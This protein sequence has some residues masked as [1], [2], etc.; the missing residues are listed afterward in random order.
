MVTFHSTSDGIFGHTSPSGFLFLILPYL[1]HNI[2]AKIGR[3]F[4]M[5]SK[6]NGLNGVIRPTKGLHGLKFIFVA[7]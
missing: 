7:Q 3:S 1:Y 5:F 6:I 2:V 4:I